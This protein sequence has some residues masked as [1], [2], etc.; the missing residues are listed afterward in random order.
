MELWTARSGSDKVIA[1]DK[2]LSKSSAQTPSRSKGTE[3]FGIR[4]CL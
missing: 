2:K 3:V 4:F 1:L